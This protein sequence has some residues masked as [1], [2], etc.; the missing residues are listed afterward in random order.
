MGGGETPPGQ[1]PR[2]AAVRYHHSVKKLIKLVVAIVVVYL[3]WT[4]GIPW[5]K[6]HFSR[7]T[8][9]SSTTATAGGSCVELAEHASETWG[10]GIGR[11]A[12]PPYDLGAWGE[13]RSR[14]DAAIAHAESQCNCA[15][16]SC[17][18]PKQ[19]MSEL[20]TL[21][22]DLDGSIR[23]GTP[24]P[25]DIVQRQES[26]DNALNAARDSLRGR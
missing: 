7:S 12:N 6:S 18:K 25:G 15:E 17:T 8:S 4:Q 19:A 16:E 24:P 3:I 1:P 21:V 10:S 5:F 23:N 20:R 2:T 14:V 9:S 13:F 11:F 26:I 22:S